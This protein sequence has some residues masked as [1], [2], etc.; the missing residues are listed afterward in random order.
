M[1]AYSCG[2]MI[3]KGSFGEVFLC[4]R[5]KTKENYVMKKMRL[6][7]VPKKEMQSFQLEVQ[8]LSELAHP[9]IVEYVESFITLDQRNL[10]IVMGYC[11][12]GDL[13]SFLKKR[14]GRHLP[15]KDIINL[16]VQITLAL[17]F[18]HTRNILHRDL[19]SQNI[20]LKDGMVQLGDFGISKVLDS[21]SA[22]AQ[23]CIGTPY[24]MSP[25]LFDNKKYN[26]KSDIWA[27]GCVLYE[28]ATLKHAFDANNLNGLAMKIRLGKYPPISSTYSRT[29]RD[30]V[31]AMLNI[32]AK[33][34]PSIK[35]ILKEKIV[36]KRLK[37]YLSK[38]FR[39]TGENKRK[40]LNLNH[41]REQLSKLGMEKILQEIEAKQK[42]TA[43]KLVSQG[44]AM[45]K[46]WKEH[47]S[48]LHEQEEA[49]NRLE[50]AF[51]KYKEEN[52]RMAQRLKERKQRDQRRAKVVKRKSTPAEIRQRKKLEDARRRREALIEH[53]AR[54][55]R[56][57][58]LRE[59]RLRGHR[60]VEKRRQQKQIDQRRNDVRS[61][62]GRKV[63]VKSTSGDDSGLSRMT[64]K[65][66]VLHKKKMRLAAEQAEREKALEMARQQLKV[67]NK[68]AENRA[69]LQYRHHGSPEH[70]EHEGDEETDEEMIE[71]KL[72]NEA[73]YEK[74]ILQRRED[75]MELKRTMGQTHVEVELNVDG[76]E[77]D[78]TEDGEIHNQTA[79]FCLSYDDSDS[80]EED[81][82]SAPPQLNMREAVQAERRLCIQ[83]LGEQGFQEGYSFVKRVHT[84]AKLAHM[85]TSKI[86][87][88][89]TKILGPLVRRRNVNVV[90]SF[91][92]LDHLHFMEQSF[93][94]K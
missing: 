10:C 81:S 59:D 22:F 77:E 48:Q 69:K 85:G 31:K 66:R 90:R 35:R 84:D 76:D 6:V 37:I 73:E 9:G 56:E 27:L 29:L 43:E 82:D 26:F 61:K 16:F 8:L 62:G 94:R 36:Q 30:L 72:K 7:N 91:N 67:E 63:S 68:I 5:K 89:F 11:E 25:E 78:E 13:T 50:E 42:K 71:E 70:S 20:F 24:Y 14:R 45:Q 44:E 83:D 15:E 54:R 12:G 57:K 86:I 2:K 92:M 80:S 74:A 51:K 1:E 47:Q 28:M 55:E 46:K 88:E 32:N 21:T 40:K 38:V 39:E 23:T 93:F 75:L 33:R 3:G 17:H 19:K 18:V 65:E 4:Q 49:Q 58:Q 34:R 52:H 87:D 60:D 64:P 53:K 79:S 41:C